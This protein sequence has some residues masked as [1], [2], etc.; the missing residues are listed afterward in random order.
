[1]SVSAAMRTVSFALLIVLMS[2]SGGSRDNVSGV[3]PTTPDAGC[4]GNCADT[5]T[6]LT[7]ADVDEV[8]LQGKL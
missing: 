3:D 4:T 5:A 8:P 1:M 6:S 2:C 7:V